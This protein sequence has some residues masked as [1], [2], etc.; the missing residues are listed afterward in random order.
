MTELRDRFTNVF[1]QDYAI[2]AP[3]GFIRYVNPEEDLTKKET[4]KTNKARQIPLSH[5]IQGTGA[6]LARTI[7]AKSINMKYG[8]LH[9]PIHDGFVFYCKK[10]LFSEALQEAQNL[11]T[12]V[13]RIIVPQV[14]MPHKI[15][16]IRGLEQ[17]A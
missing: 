9:M 3:G 16:W 4:I 2:T 12:S 5:I 14:E 11:L 17:Q 6:Y 15:E 8:R 13:A 1:F 10:N 7:I